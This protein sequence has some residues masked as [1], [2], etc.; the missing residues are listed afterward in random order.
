LHVRV[1][2]PIWLRLDGG[3]LTACVINSSIH[4][5]QFVLSISVEL[6]TEAQVA[7]RFCPPTA[8]AFIKEGNALDELDSD[9]HGFLSELDAL[10]IETI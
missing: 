5:N 6:R 3:A 1:L 8:L 2:R 7:S 10:M 4:Q 9:G